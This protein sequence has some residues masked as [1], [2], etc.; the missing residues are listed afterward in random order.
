MILRCCNWL[1]AIEK[2]FIIVWDFYD[3]DG[4]EPSLGNLSTCR[5]I[6]VALENEL[7]CTVATV[8][9][10]SFQRERAILIVVGKIK[11]VMSLILKEDLRVLLS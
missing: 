11:S 4:L 9:V 8:V 7:H 3:C 10:E 6:L 1:H 2:L 5:N